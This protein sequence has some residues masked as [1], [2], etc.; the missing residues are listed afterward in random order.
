MTKLTEAEDILRD[1]RHGQR[2]AARLREALTWE[3]VPGFKIAVHVQGLFASSSTYNQTEAPALDAAMALVIR[4]RLDELL[5][6]AQALLDRQEAE[7]RRSLLDL[8]LTIAT[9]KADLAA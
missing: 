6:D 4:N 8:A 7:R 2:I 1:T 5:A 9:R 3:R